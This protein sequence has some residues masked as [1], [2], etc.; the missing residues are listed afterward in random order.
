M[1]IK[2]LHRLVVKALEIS[3]LGLLLIL[4]VACSQTEEP[5]TTVE[6][7]NPDDAVAFTISAGKPTRAFTTFDNYWTA[8]QKISVKGKRIDFTKESLAEETKVF[9]YKA[10]K[11]S[12]ASEGRV[13]IIPEVGNNRADW[14]PDNTFFWSTRVTSRTFSAWYPAAESEPSSKTVP[15]DQTETALTIY[16]RDTYYDYDI[17]YAPE[18]TVGF[19]ETVDL[20]FY[21]QLCRIIVTV[22][23]AATKRSKPVTEIKFGKQNIATSVT[24]TNLGVTGSRSSG[25]MTV[26]S[27][28]AD[29]AKNKDIVMRLKSADSN[30][31]V[32][33]YECIVPPQSLPA[34]N[35]LFQI[36]LHDSQSETKPY[37]ILE[38][39]PSE[40]YQDAPNFQAGYQYNYSITL[41]AAGMVNISSVQVYDWTTETI[42]G[43]NATVP[44][45]SY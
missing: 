12:S 43:L 39:K 42:T 3:I 41:S 33:T 36:K 26:W 7:D 1:M 45:G 14:T 11:S 30:S 35:V 2:V 27:E 32:Y 18:V 4:T 23:S 6:G 40:M 10:K 17:L 21:H 25:A 8:D 5:T 16:G 19:K 24:Y 15:E 37:P 20:T 28:P 22:N 29:A 44:D 9:T 34:T 13:E 38:Y 31:H